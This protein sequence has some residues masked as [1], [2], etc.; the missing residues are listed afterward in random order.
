MALKYADRVKETT[1]TTGTG[2]Y[3]LAGAAVGFQSFAAI[4]DGNTCH[5]TV[6]DG[7]NWEI[8]LGTYTAATTSLARTSI[9]ASSNG[10]VAVNWGAG[11]KD[12]FVTIPAEVAG[13]RDAQVFTASGTW[14]KPVGANM[15]RIMCIGGGGGGGSGYCGSST[16]SGGNGGNGGNVASMTF[17]AGDLPDS[18]TVTVGAGGAGGAGYPLDTAGYN[19]G[20]EGGYSCVADGSNYLLLANGGKK[21]NGGRATTTTIANFNSEH[22][23]YETKLTS[24]VLSNAG[25][26]TSSSGGSAVSTFGFI[27]SGGGGGGSIGTVSGGD[28]GSISC[29][30][31][32]GPAVSTIYSGGIGAIAS[33]LTPAGNGSTHPFTLMGTGGGGGC[34]G[35]PELRNGGNGGLY[36]GGG[37]G[38]STG[39]LGS[40]DSGAGG[41]GGDGLVVIWSW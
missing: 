35:Y 12:V 10:G 32:G 29:Q 34:A 22:P 33:S 8:G 21:G 37:G 41:N 3:T 25:Q 30:N 16:R 4:G 14:T 11:D 20:S 24:T 5:Y 36:G 7:A 39:L 27:P 17:H 28:G 9:I 6:T 40:Y 23:I 26:G 38:G 2:D 1:A 13:A 15:V 31:G 18:L 19:D